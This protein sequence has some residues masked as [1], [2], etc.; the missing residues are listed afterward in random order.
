M[1]KQ[2]ACKKCRT[3][4]EG[5]KCPKCGSIEAVDNF[6]GKVA[7]LNTEESEIAKNLEIKEKGIYAT[8]LR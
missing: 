4:Y 7:I 1:A 2:K 8:R 5:V 3:I 6:K